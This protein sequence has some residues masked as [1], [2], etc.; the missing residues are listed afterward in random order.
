[1]QVYKKTY[2]RWLNLQADQLFPEN[3][4]HDGVNITATHHLPF[5]ATTEQVSR[6]LLQNLQNANSGHFQKTL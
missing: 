1:M 3:Q 5:T 6:G 4:G 2:L